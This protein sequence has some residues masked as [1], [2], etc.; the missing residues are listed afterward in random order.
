MLPIARA[1]SGALVINNNTLALAPA[2]VM[3]AAKARVPVPT[4]L[5]AKA[6]APMPAKAVAMASAPMPTQAAT[7]AETGMPAELFHPPGIVVKQI[8]GIE[9]DML[10]SD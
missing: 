1:D 5:A 6:R 9:M 8:L 10:N 4:K 7:K 3:A 2:P